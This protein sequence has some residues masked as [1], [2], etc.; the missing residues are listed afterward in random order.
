[1]HDQ[2]WG[3]VAQVAQEIGPAG[4]VMDQGGQDVNGDIRPLFQGVTEWISVDLADTPGVTIVADCGD[5]THPELCD[6]V[7][8]T[9]LLEHTPRGQ[10]I[11]GHAYESL[12]PGG[13]YIVTTAAPGRPVHNATGGP[14]LAEGE[15]YRN[16]SY[17]ELNGWLERAGFT[18]IIISTIG[19]PFH[20][21]IRAWARKP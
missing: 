16:I 4:R 9:E 10:D 13:H 5:Y 20:I 15:H 7:V 19:A 14:E 12:K 2:A 11:I 8:T 1:M 3:W 21:D 17:D 18:H 6:V